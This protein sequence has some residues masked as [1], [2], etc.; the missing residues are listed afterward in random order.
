[1]RTYQSYQLTLCR[2]EKEFKLVF[3]KELWPRW[4]TMYERA[5]ETHASDF[6]AVI[7]RYFFLRYAPILTPILMHAKRA[8]ITPTDFS[9]WHYFERS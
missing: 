4:I 6:F 1:M 5:P 8:N 9:A 3:L 7:L 2:K